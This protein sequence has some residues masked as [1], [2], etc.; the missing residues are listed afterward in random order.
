M[1]PCRRLFAPGATA[2]PPV[3]CGAWLKDGILGDPPSLIYEPMLFGAAAAGRDLRVE[4][5]GDPFGG[6]QAGFDRRVFAG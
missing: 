4:I 5:H 1:I 6:D 2:L 3:G